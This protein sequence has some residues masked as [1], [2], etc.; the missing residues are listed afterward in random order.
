MRQP[1]FLIV[2]LSNLSVVYSQHNDPIVAN[3][4]DSLV[5]APGILATSKPVMNAVKTDAF[6]WFFGTGV[7]KYERFFSDNIS[8]QLAWFFKHLRLIIFL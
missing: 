3:E 8:V 7:L 4:S 6:S 2:I 1:V 5:E